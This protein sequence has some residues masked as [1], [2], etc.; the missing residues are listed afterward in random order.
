MPEVGVLLVN[1]GSPDE[2]TVPAIKNYLE[3][4]LMDPRIRP[5]PR[6]PWSL[7]LH[8]RILPT[9]PAALLEKYRTIW[10]PEGSPLIAAHRHLAEKLTARFDE[11]CVPAAV[12]FAMSYSEPSIRSALDE[13]AGAG[14][15]RVV[16]LPLYPQSAFSTTGAV[17]DAVRKAAKRV[18]PRIAIDIVENYHDDP[19]YLKA[20]A[21]S[22]VDAGFEPDSTDRLVFSFHSIPLTDIEAGD[23][24]E[25][26]IGASCLA[27]AEELGLD[28]RRWTIGYQS[29]FDRDRTW[30]SPFTRQTLS[31]WAEQAIEDRLFIVCPN[32]AADGLETLY[33]IDG[34]LRDEY[35]AQR[36]AHDPHARGAHAPVNAG[37]ADEDAFT[38]VPC[39]ND[40]DTHVAVIEHVLAPH[41]GIAC[42]AA[43]EANERRS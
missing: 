23:T 36:R 25:L 5:M 8:R 31:T 33:D 13:L 29:Q 19:C 22:V 41:L 43:N 7:I 6:L 24:Y 40:S 4:F 10:T 12:R 32:F 20:I 27:I 18:K 15:A 37:L 11:R 21:R 16:V 3:R 14:C 42:D 17:T 28:R 2:L 38:Y 1:T 35:L 9:R 34:V 26:Q 39:L 30:L